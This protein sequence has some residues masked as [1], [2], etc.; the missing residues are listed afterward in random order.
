MIEF[1]SNIAVMLT[2]QLAQS[3][4]NTVASKIVEETKSVTD[5]VSN[6][7]TIVKLIVDEVFSQ[8]KSNAVIELDP[9]VAGPGTSINFI[10]STPGGPVTGPFSP[11]GNSVKG[12]I[13]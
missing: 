7:Q 6:W 12:K 5:P 11:P 3:I 8:I 1:G 10:A 4:A 2:P 13:T 9:V